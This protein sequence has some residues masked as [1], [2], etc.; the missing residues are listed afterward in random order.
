MPAAYV[1][2]Y[3][4]RHRNDAADAEAICERS[5]D[6]TCGST[7]IAR[8]RSAGVRAPNTSFKT[9]CSAKAFGMRQA[10]QPPGF[11]LC[12]APQ[13]Q[14]DRSSLARGRRSDRRAIARGRAA[15]VS[16]AAP[17]PTPNAH[18]SSPSMS[19]KSGVQSDRIRHLCHNERLTACQNEI[20]PSYNPLKSLV[21]AQGLEPWARQEA[22][23]IPLKSTS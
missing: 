11:V 10:G 7:L 21:G 17:D 3:V 8:H 22:V 23:F 15:S 9:A 4:K 6:L 13:T 12:S 1:K 16:E 20:L 2:P 14:S 18:V 5:P 19:P